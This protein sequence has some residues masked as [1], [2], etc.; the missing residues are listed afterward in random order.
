MPTNLYGPGDNFH[1]K[2]S[3]VLP[4]LTRRFNEAAQQGMKEVTIWGS[5]TPRREFLR[6]DDMEKA[7]MFVLDLD[8]ETYAANTD[9]ML[10]HI[11]VGTGTD[12]SIMELA[13]MVARVTGFKGEILT[14]PSKPVGTMRK[15]MDVSRLEN[16]GWSA[17]V[18]LFERIRKTISWYIENSEN[19][20]K[21]IDAQLLSA[22][23]TL[24]RFLLC[25]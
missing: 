3:H 6:V 23:A 15:L 20:R 13:Q 11:N 10:S 17:K 14:D 19:L 25:T 7:S 2:N 9:P 18:K 5:G 12:V 24:L 22:R 8:Q 21:E 1:P 16:M 4:A